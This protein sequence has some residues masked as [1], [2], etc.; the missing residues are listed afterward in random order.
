MNTTHLFYRFSAVAV[1]AT[2]SCTFAW[3]I[4][5]QTAATT[6]DTTVRLSVCGDG[7]IEGPE[8]CESANLNSQSC[9]SIGYASG[10]LTCDT[11]CSFDTSNCIPPTP[12]PTPLPTPPPTPS[13]EPTQSPS[14]QPTPDSSSQTPSDAATP[15]PTVTPIVNRLFSLPFLQPAPAQP[16]PSGPSLP[17]PLLTL[18]SPVLQRNGVASTPNAIPRTQLEPVISTWV[19]EWKKVALSDSSLS[20]STRNSSPAN[21]PLESSRQT[22]NT[23]TTEK[24]C[25]LNQDETCNTQDFSVLLYYVES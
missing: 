2:I 20:P 6:I 18:I 7:V 12:T 23:N 17:P 5:A 9:T 14:P 8:D 3:Q 11:A 25:D 13:P 22:P 10:S 1:M 15:T 24:T 16:Q 21:F 4:R 19:E